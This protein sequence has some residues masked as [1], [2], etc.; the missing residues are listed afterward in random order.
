MLGVSLEALIKLE[1]ELKHCA[2][3]ALDIK[4]DRELT[5]QDVEPLAEKILIY[6]LVKHGLFR[7]AVSYEFSKTECLGVTQRRGLIRLA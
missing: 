7:Q 2:Q 5:P 4:K 1:I 3:T 6:S